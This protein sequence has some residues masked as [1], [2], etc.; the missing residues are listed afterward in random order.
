MSSSSAMNRKSESLFS[1]FSAVM[2]NCYQHFCCLTRALE[3]SILAYEGQD[4]LEQ[5]TKYI[6]WLEENYPK[7]G[8]E[9]DLL[10]VLE[11]VKNFSCFFF[12]AISLNHFLF[13]V[14]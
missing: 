7:G 1:P 12:Q 13:P 5:W 3:L 8:K 10:I 4:P 6:N 2:S 14:S 11:Q 9:G